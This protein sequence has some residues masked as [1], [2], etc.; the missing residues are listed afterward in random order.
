VSLYPVFSISIET[1]TFLITVHSPYKNQT[2]VMVS[3][4]SILFGNQSKK[5]SQTMIA[6][7]NE[8]NRRKYFFKNAY[9]KEP[10]TRYEMADPR[11]KYPAMT[12]KSIL[13]TG[14]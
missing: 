3:A 10:Q 11:L 12:D 8:R 2:L 7:L 6:I 4:K 5:M 1:I 13:R 9:A 14:P